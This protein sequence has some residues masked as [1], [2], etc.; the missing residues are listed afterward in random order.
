MAD[1]SVAVL[2]ERLTGASVT[3]DQTVRLS[4]LHR[5]VVHAWLTRKGVSFNSQAFE[6]PSFTLSSLLGES[7]APVL[8]AASTKAVRSRTLRGVGIDIQRVA[9]MPVATDYRS[10]PFY[11]SNFTPAEIAHCICQEDARQSFCGLWAAKEAILKTAADSEKPMDLGAISIV[12]EASGRPDFAG[13]DLSISH[14]GDVCVA[15]FLA[16]VAQSPAQPPA[17]QR[18]SPAV[19]TEVLKTRG[20]GFGNFFATVVATAIIV[21]LATYLLS[22]RL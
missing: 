1:E 22:H 17:E 14:D 7:A 2:L 8:P 16:H 6:Q 21:G 12:H 9:K 19:S 10:D 13:G 4:S 18:A 3:P 20:Q 5:A 11:S 15:V